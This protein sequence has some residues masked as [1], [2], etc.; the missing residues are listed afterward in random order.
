MPKTTTNVT[1]FTSAASS[2]RLALSPRATAPVPTQ[3]SPLS[4]TA[5]SAVPQ[6]ADTYPYGSHSPRQRQPARQHLKPSP[7]H[8]PGSGRPGEGAS[9]LLNENGLR[10]SNSFMRCAS[11]AWPRQSPAPAPGMGSAPNT[12]SVQAGDHLDA[13]ALVSHQLSSTRS[14]HNGLALYTNPLAAEAQLP[15]P[16]AP[17]CTPS[18]TAVPRV[19][20]AEAQGAE[21]GLLMADPPFPVAG[22]GAYDLTDPVIEADT[23]AGRK[24][25]S[26]P[27]VAAPLP[28]HPSHPTHPIPADPAAPATPSLAALLAAAATSPDPA[29]LD[30][31]SSSAKLDR[32]AWAEG[33]AGPGEAT[34]RPA[35][36]GLAY[37]LRCSSMASSSYSS[38]ASADQLDIGPLSLMARLRRWLTLAGTWLAGDEAGQASQQGLDSADRKGEDSQGLGAPNGGVHHRL[39]TVSQG[40]TVAGLDSG[41]PLYSGKAL[42][43]LDTENPVRLFCY[44]VCTSAV[45]ENL[46]L[47]VILASCLTMT[48]ES[49]RVAPDSSLGHGLYVSE[50]VFTALFGLEMVVKVLALGFVPYIRHWQ[51]AIDCVVVITAVLEL[52]VGGLRWFS[53]LRVLRLIKPLMRSQGMRQVLKAVVIAIWSMG[54]V[55]M[56]CIL[57]L[58]MFATMGSVLF[59]GR[60]AS[61]SDPS[62]G[63]EEQCDGLFLPPGQSQQSEREWAV[64]YP[65]FDN[66]GSSLIVLLITC[67]L[68]GYTP[69]LLHSMDAPYRMG[70]QPR[71][72]NMPAA[73]LF[74]V[75][76]VLVCA[77]VLINLYV[78]V[79]FTQF[80]RIT[81]QEE[82]T[83]SMSLDEQQWAMLQH[84]VFSLR[85]MEAVHHHSVQAQEVARQRT[86]QQAAKE[87]K[88]LE[89]QS[90]HD[91]QLQQLWLPRKPSEMQA[92]QP[93]G[94]H[95]THQDRE[96]GQGQAASLDT[97]QGQVP[98]QQQAVCPAPF[99]PAAGQ[100]CA[101]SNQASQAKLSV[102]ADTTSQPAAYATVFSQ[103]AALQQHSA[104]Q[105]GDFAFSTA[106]KLAAAWYE[107]D[108]KLGEAKATGP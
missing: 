39:R 33:G 101:E 78:G 29:P 38:F 73:L 62:V 105:G 44:R 32:P 72:N 2:P 16:A 3:P 48:L 5:S 96:T 9:F 104:Q 68:N 35:V 7:C 76:F 84:K 42:W 55:T 17:S 97:L 30:R 95:N 108:G 52:S 8:C 57:L 49:P 92:G 60:F 31:P 107:A 90:R 58:L 69:S 37:Q 100:P 106:H 20:W 28:S 53:A 56:V 74:Y 36:Y 24:Q 103:A 65:N 63:N 1:H 34:G 10:D 11:Q 19:G 47:A 89:A 14:Q 22:E 88:E 54:A 21:K 15:V 23:Q 18:T 25:D 26:P 82:G 41:T 91:T 46:M 87:S 6:L 70:D 83:S 4:R 67:S 75:I 94:L 27:Q 45:F 64:P 13:D 85:L 66:I 50:L 40:S 79:I 59:R 93:C 86:H 61:C 102:S 81:A 43:L 98:G 77:L 51:N 99:Q 71:Y 80:S 12:L